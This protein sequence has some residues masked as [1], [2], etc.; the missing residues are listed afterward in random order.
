[1]RAASGGGNGEGPDRRHTLVSIVSIVGLVIVWEALTATRV[2]DPA[3]FPPPSRVTWEGLKLIRSGE[4]F[5]D[6][7]MS[8]RRVLMGFVVS[9]L[10]AVPLGIAIG[11]SRF[12]KAVFDPIVS[13]IRPLPSLSWI[14][15]SM[16]WLGIGESQKY[17]IVFMGSLAPLL[18]Y[19]IDATMQVDPI[20][21]KAAQN[22]GASRLQIMREVILPGALPAILS[23]LKVGL[24]LGWT[25]IISAEMVGSTDGL[26]FLIWNAKDWANMPQVIIGMMGISVT[27]LLLD[28]L[29]RGVETRLLPWQR[30]YRS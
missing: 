17:A 9:G 29:F 28:W 12:L 4:I 24:A 19:V 20:L 23:G 30:L 25:C 18:L 1:M 26:G 8:S 10:V 6:M 21:I 3:F 27:V 7:W 2:I 15:L 22:L 13:V 11:S 5:H 16:L 14:P